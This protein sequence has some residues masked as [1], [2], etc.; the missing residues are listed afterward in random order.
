MP[1]PI[2]I[3]GVRPDRSSILL[4]EV[5]EMEAYGSAE[6]L[7]GNYALGAVGCKRAGIKALEWFLGTEHE[8]ALICQDDCHWVDDAAVKVDA[9]MANLPKKWDVLYFSA[10]DR[11]PTTPVNDYWR[12][13]TGARLCTAILWTRQAAEKLLPALQVSGREWDFFMET[14]HPNILAFRMVDMPAY[15]NPDISDIAGHF[16]KP[17]NKA[18]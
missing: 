8:Q 6:N 10:H 13:L 18:L 12:Q 9:A 14:Q 2:F 17:S 4:D 7:R 11:T 16:V 3:D 15:Q 1:T 5:C